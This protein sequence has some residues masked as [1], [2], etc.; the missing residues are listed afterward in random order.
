MPNVRL[1]P[2]IAGMALAA[3]LLAA[4]AGRAADMPRFPMPEPVKG[5]SETIY[6]FRSG[7]Y[8]RGDIGYRYNKMTGIDATPAVTARSLD[9]NVTFG[10]GF[11][12]KHGFLRADVTLD[13]GIRTPIRGGVGGNPAFYSGKLDTVTALFNG[14]VDLGTWEGI[15]PYVG[16]GIGA[17]RM[18]LTDYMTNATAPAT[19]IPT[20]QTWQMS[21]AA[22]A[23]FSYQFMPNMALDVG[24]RYLKMG[25]AI[26]GPDSAG[27]VAKFRNLS[28]Q[29]VRVGLRFMIDY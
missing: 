15:T 20:A 23:G 9:N 2:F 27:N 19:A 10:G 13:Y 29:E 1:I 18:N 26:S 16:A 22:M 28:A 11:G 17:T 21:W 8:L 14:Y 12:Y 3:G 25:D 24:Y 4:G 7:W 5:G 6:E